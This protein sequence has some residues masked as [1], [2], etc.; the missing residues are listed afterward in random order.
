MNT[1]THT[2]LSWSISYLEHNTNDQVRSKINFLV[3]PQEPLLATVK[4]RKLA[5]FGHVTCHDSLSE[6]ILQSALESGRRLG[7]QRKCWMD[8]IKEWTPLPMPELLTVTR[9]SFRKDWK[10][11]SAESSAMSPRPPN[12]LSDWTEL[13]LKYMVLW[14]YIFTV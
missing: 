13:N 1:F 7:R 12:R 10:G 11:I 14:T 3:G 9:A 8:N 5:R 2:S 6:T 4:R